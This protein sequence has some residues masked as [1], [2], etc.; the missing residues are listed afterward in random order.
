[1]T[2][3]DWNPAQYHRFQDERSRPFHD[4]LAMV[5]VERPMG[6]VADLGCGSG[7]LTA[8]VAE[9][10]GA[11]D[12][13]GVDNSPAMLAAAA[14]HTRPGL[15]FVDGDLGA[16]TSAAD[17]DLVIANAS[18]QWVSDHAAVLARWVQAL[19]PGGQLAVQV[20]SNADQPSHLVAAEVAARPHFAEA[21]G[22][23]GPPEDPVARNVPAPEAYARLLHALGFAEQRV[24]LEVYPHLLP[25]SRSVVEWVKGTTLTRFQKRLPADVFARFLAEYEERLLEVIGRGAPYFF[26]FKR[27]LLWGRLPA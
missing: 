25:E 18:L 10:T 11:A 17:H 12:C 15:R 16:W 26:P 19:A 8:L 3:A 7:E 6:R 13:V 5:R 14:A 20:P 24:L 9:R 22:P 27:V 1:M 21:F 2:H 4:L 23:S